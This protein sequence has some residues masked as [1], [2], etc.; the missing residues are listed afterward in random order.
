MQEVKYRGIVL[1]VNDY[2]EYDKRL[3]ILTK[4]AGKIT[5]FAHGA[6]RPN[7]QMASAANSFVMGE[8]DLYQSGT[9]Y[10]L[11]SANIENYFFE[12]SQDMEK[13]CYAAYFCELA[14]Y[15]CVEGSPAGEFLNLLYAAQKLL[16]G[17]R[18]DFKLIR[19][20]YEEKIVVLDG[21]G[22]NSDTLLRL[23]EYRS[24]MPLEETVKYAF[25]YVLEA[26]LS[27]VFAFR[28]N[29]RYMQ[30]FLKLTAAYLK[31]NI[32]HPMKSLPILEAMYP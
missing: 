18:I 1:Y 23:P 11:K 22:I 6:R 21:E 17:S 27:K 15:F 29:D 8:F 19:A 16:A 2:G 25:D 7:S 32:D 3:V 9:A 5:A 13:T 4:E 24:F 26:P 28:L 31:N 12:L 14:S 30:T 20:V 10:S